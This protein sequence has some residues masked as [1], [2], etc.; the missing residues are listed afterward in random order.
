[1]RSRESWPV[2]PE[3]IWDALSMVQ[4]PYYRGE[5][6]CNMG[7]YSEPACITDQPLEGWEAQIT[8]AGWPL[9]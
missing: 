7:C 9:P 5:G 2:P 1:M 8:A 4:C 3:E 6:T